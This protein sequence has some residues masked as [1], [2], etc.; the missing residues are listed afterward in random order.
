M[1]LGNTAQLKSYIRYMGL[2]WGIIYWIKWE[3]PN[4]IK[5]KGKMKNTITKKQA[6]KSRDNFLEYFLR[7]RRN[8]NKERANQ[9]LNLAIALNNLAN[10]PTKPSN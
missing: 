7:A 10:P 1:Y 6:K 5:K 8:G 4:Q 2:F 3:N 9:F